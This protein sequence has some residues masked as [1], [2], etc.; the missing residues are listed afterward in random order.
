M[1]AVHLT[2]DPVAAGLLYKEQQSP[3]G[4]EV[5]ELGWKSAYSFLLCYHESFPYFS[6]L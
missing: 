3:I 5:L 1:Q 4:R 6:S 2:S